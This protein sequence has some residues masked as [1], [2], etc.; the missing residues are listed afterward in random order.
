M[1][2]HPFSH[3][4]HHQ[5]RKSAEAVRTVLCLPHVR[6]VA[7]SSVVARLPKGMVPLATVLLLHQVTGSYAIAGITA[8]LVAV[9][10]AASTP[11]QGRLADRLGRGIVLIPIAAVNVASV[12]AMLLLA[13]DGGPTFALAA[14]AC[15]AG[16]G[17][18]P[19]SG[20]IKAVWPQLASQDQLSAAY[21]VES[22]LQQLVFLSGPL[23]VAVLAPAG[24][25]A[26]AL[27]CSA[28]LV[29]GGTVSFVAVAARTTP[30]RGRRPH[31]GPSAWRVPAVRT[32][33]YCTALQ[34][35]TFGALPVGLAAVT[36]RAGLPN[37][38]GV[39]LATL[40]I[41]GVAGTFGPMA[42]AGRRRYV[43]LM[44]GF[45]AALMAAAALSAVPSP[46]AL[47][48]IGAT[49][50]AAGLFLTPMAAASYLLIE[51]A[52]TPAHRTE[53]FTW[54]SAAQ[55]TGNAAGAALAGTLTA[56]VGPA[57]ALGTLPVAV[58]LAV[59]IG[60]LSR[61]TERGARP[62]SGTR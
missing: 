7:V 23:L 39:L 35:L 18:P 16:I 59:L 5:V 53:A 25:P 36:A 6:P 32:L 8:A 26:A 61:L 13:R 30:G 62:A 57:L 34:S 46:A 45:A 22:L 27:A 55:A 12:T 40:T 50:A 4:V 17:M 47:I 37:L 58:G 2:P 10:D 38:A 43:R 52:A 44:T 49:L 33:V 21:T 54:L 14:C 42:T 11:L 19:V 48:A 15:V 51:R 20:S 24:G 56:S 3:A 41:G 9:G 1:S 29:A 31:R 28:A 60:R